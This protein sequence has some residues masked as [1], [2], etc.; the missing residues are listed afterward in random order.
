METVTEPVGPTSA[1][2]G[3]DNI[4]FEGLGELLQKNREQAQEEPA[5]V[6]EQTEAGAE[7][8]ETE[9]TP[10]VEQPDEVEDQPTDEE[11]EEAEAQDADDVEESDGLD[12]KA[13]KSINQRIGKL[14]SQRK[15]A[16]EQRQEAESQLAKMQE[17]NDKLQEQLDKQG[18]QSLLASDPL[19]DVL[20]KKELKEKARQCRDWRRW[21]TL[22]RDGGEFNTPDGGTKEYDSQEVADI[23]KYADDMLEEHLPAREKWLENHA[24]MSQVAKEQF[25]AWKD[26]SNPVYSEYQEILR[27]FPGLKQFPNYQVLA[28]IFHMG[29]G[30]YNN[31]LQEK[32][33]AS[34]P[35]PKKV[36]KPTEPTKVS[37]PT[38][39]PPPASAT[40]KV[41]AVNDAEKWVEDSNG[42]A[43]AVMQLLK[44]RRT[45]SAA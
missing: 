41:N 20:T 43:D 22:N 4:S 5:A 40:K 16:E 21:A 7:E 19:A 8:P 31:A 36:A 11:T 27:E 23:L 12:D 35:K 2:N 38:S 44:A 13:Q 18:T 15:R 6:D 3:V 14:T 26:T 34:K 25:P 30:A 37:A 1:E 9:S 29:L 17:R 24:Q 39:V 28:G 45:V 42:S 33:Q 10:E 32:T